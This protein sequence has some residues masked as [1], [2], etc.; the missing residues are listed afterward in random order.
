MDAANGHDWRDGSEAPSDSSD[1]YSTDPA[2]PAI[3]GPVDATTTGSAPGTD[4]QM[5]D[6]AEGDGAR[7]DVDSASDMD[8]S[9]PSQPTSPLSAT[10]N[11]LPAIS[12]AIAIAIVA[13]QAIATTGTSLAGAKRK[14]SDA[15]GDTDGASTDATD[16][17]T[18]KRRVDSAQTPRLPTDIWQRVFMLL[19]PAVLCRCLRV[20]KD[21]NH[22]LTATKA[23][24]G[25]Q[26]DKSTA[27]IV[28][29]EAIWTHSR[30]IFFPQLP[31]PLRQHTELEMLKLV[32]GQNCQFC[33]KAPVASPATS[34][35]NC[36]PGTDGVRVIFPFGV[37]TCGPCIEP[38]LRKVCVRRVDILVFT[39]SQPGRTASCRANIRTPAIRNLP[40]IPQRGVPLRHRHSPSDAAR[41]HFKFEILQGVLSAAPGS[42]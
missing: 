5:P 21:F 36:G 10:A 41:H 1:F 38:F 39:D 34:V 19:P 18:K 2:L 14:L 4:T 17:Q 40:C 6:G 25:Q 23:P 24:Q 26:K 37:R 27:R 13:E 11:A 9:E 42:H 28:D 3:P 22:M 15:E 33:G 12:D 30:K 29:S 8:C 7:D 20:C 16:E 35:F 31:R 32:G